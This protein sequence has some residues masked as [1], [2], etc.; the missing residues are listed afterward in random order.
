MKT[1]TDMA[2]MK[3]GYFGTGIFNRLAWSL[4]IG[5]CA[6]LLA[7]TG[8]VGRLFY[9][10]T[11]AIYS[12]PDQW[13]LAYE[14]VVFEAADGYRLSGWF[15]PASPKPAV[16]TVVHFHG[17][18]QNMTAHYQYVAWL[19]AAGFNLLVFDY[20]GYGAS[21]GVPTRR[22]LHLDGLAA[23]RYVQS[24]PDVDPNRLV[25]VGQSLGADVA[26]ALA[27]R[28]ALPG[29]KAVVADSA[30]YSYQSIVR[31]KIALIPVL[32]T[33]KWPLSWL[34]VGNSYSPGP[35]VQRI[36]PIPVFL[37]HGSADRIVPYH[38]VRALYQAAREPKQLITLPDQG[39]T[40]GLL[41][42]NQLVRMELLRALRACLEAGVDAKKY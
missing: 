42:T 33:L 30:F 9:F 31:D 4:R 39:H 8:C 16:G 2:S 32:W 27:G 3:A 12:T 21:P 26:L 20:R 34:V 7:L 1:T 10:P 35:V 23:I 6:G 24:R 18:A 37:M 17:N 25:L 29:V 14:P 5:M 19:P 36:S 22:G 28:E 40:T 38:H 15:L 41:A 11:G 13:N